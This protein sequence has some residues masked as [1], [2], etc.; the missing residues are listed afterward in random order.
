MIFKYKELK[1]CVEEDF[2]R[3]YKMDFNEN[4]IFP[5]V[6]SEYEHGKDFSPVEK[7][8]IHI[9]LILFYNPKDLNCNQIIDGLNQLMNEKNE[10][11]IKDELGSEYLEFI[12]DLRMTGISK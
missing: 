8:C 5:A 3:F 7:I 2:D 6:L 12:A 11:E 4:Q 10:S 1:E 9:F